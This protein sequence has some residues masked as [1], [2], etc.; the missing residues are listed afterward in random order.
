VM[1]KSVLSATI[2]LGVALSPM[3]V[4]SPAEAAVGTWLLFPKYGLMCIPNLDNCA[5]RFFSGPMV[6]MSRWWTMKRTVTVYG[7]GSRM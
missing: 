3:L 5:G 4:S 1:R 2:A 7:C 6:T